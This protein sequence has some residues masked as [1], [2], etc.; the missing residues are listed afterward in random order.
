MRWNVLEQ[1]CPLISAKTFLLADP[2]ERERWS[3]REKEVFW[4]RWGG[5]IEGLRLSKT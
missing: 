5:G 4:R 3:E 2:N 1:T